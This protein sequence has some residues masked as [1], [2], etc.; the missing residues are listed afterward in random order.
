MKQSTK[1][2]SKEDMLKI[3]KSFEE[4]ARIVDNIGKSRKNKNKKNKQSRR[5]GTAM[6]G[7]ELKVPCEVASKMIMGFVV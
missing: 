2:W 7:V 4:C 5:G 1:Q 6:L 3:A